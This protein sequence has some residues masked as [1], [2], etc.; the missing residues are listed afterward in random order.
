MTSPPPTR[1]VLLTNRNQSAR[2][3]LFCFPCA[4]KGA[5]VFNGWTRSFPSDVDVCPIQMPGR[6]NRL[7]EP[8]ITR[9]SLLVEDLS[10]H[11]TAYLDIPFAFF[12]HSMG[13]LIGFEFARQLRRQ[14][15]AGPTHL[16]VSS[17]RAPHLLPAV[18]P[19]APAALNRAQG[20]RGEWQGRHADDELMALMLPTLQADLSL[21][22]TYAY[23]P[24]EPLGCP[25]SAFGGMRDPAITREDLAAWRLHTKSSF[26]VRMFPGGHFYFEAEQ[27][28]LI[29][30]I[31]EDLMGR[32]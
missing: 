26:S 23:S 12:G 28:A 25:V 14:L 20:L 5:S 3:R 2:L 8:P 1:W 22:E 6:E 24:E 32:A 4:G 21:C 29:R 27:A 13:G 30:A 31:H 16:F 17:C 11:L 18:R 15:R 19:G 9:L 7:M 10:R